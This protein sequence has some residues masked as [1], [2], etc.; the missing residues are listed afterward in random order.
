M[1]ALTGCSFDAEFEIYLCADMSAVP[2]FASTP[3][4]SAAHTA[5]AEHDPYFPT[6]SSAQ[7]TDIHEEPQ[8]Y[9]ARAEQ[10]DD[11]GILLESAGP[12]RQVSP[13]S[14]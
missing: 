8:H 1:S 3:M 7:S 5:A 10:Y 13:S 6:V 12:S 4:S 2:S 14:P 9:S 11:D